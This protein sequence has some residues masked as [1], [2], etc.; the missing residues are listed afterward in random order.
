M[1]IRKFPVNCGV[2][3]TSVLKGLPKK[4]LVV[5]LEEKFVV[6]L[7]LEQE[8]EGVLLVVYNDKKHNLKY[9]LLI[10]VRFIKLLSPFFALD[11][12]LWHTLLLI[13]IL[14]FSLTPVSP[15]SLIITWWQWMGFEVFDC[16]VIV[17]LLMC[18]LCVYQGWHQQ[19]SFSSSTKESGDK[20]WTQCLKSCY[21]EVNCDSC[22]ILIR[23]LH[24]QLRCICA[25]TVR[26]NKT[27]FIG[28]NL[29]GVTIYSELESI[30]SCNFGTAEVYVI[31]FLNRWYVI[32]DVGN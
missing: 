8:W 17:S 5:Y 6:Q 14:F 23:M 16:F 12:K 27:R 20:V 28:M 10:L 22:V 19:R 26:C 2:F 25:L 7:F 1:C 31:L 15:F 30:M 4:L 9:F 29:F 24:H 32:S 18:S 11:I 3:L 13:L 21:T